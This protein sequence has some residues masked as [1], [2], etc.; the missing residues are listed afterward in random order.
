MKEKAGPSWLRLAAVPSVLWTVSLLVL[1]AHAMWRAPPFE[2]AASAHCSQLLIPLVIPIER[3]PQALGFDD[4]LSIVYW[5]DE[6]TGKE[7]KTFIPGERA[8]NCKTIED[9][10]KL[11]SDGAR[12]G[13]VA[14][15][16]AVHVGR[17]AGLL[18]GPIFFFF[19]ASFLL[20]GAGGSHQPG[21]TAR[22][23]RTA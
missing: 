7:I 15:K 18:I 19:V 8:L 12:L 6:K 21:R 22:R 4:Y 20:V 17:F 1:V 14:P 9:R 2:K 16:K 23:K 10:A 13:I 3:A 11:F 5:R